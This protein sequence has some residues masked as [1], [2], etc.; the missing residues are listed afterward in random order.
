M[1]VH[2]YQELAVNLAD[3]KQQLGQVEALLLEDPHNDE[4]QSMY[5]GLHEVRSSQ[6]A[7]RAS[8]ARVRV[9]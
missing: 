7:K 6:I 2:S 3:Y 5:D 4:L 1:E 9:A 8:M